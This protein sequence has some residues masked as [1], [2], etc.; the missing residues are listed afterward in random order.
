MPDSR[1]E[2]GCSCPACGADGTVGI[3]AV[4]NAPTNSCLLVDTVDEAIAFPRGRVDLRLCTGCGFVFNAA[5][6]PAKTVY[7]GRYEE[8]QGY[9]ATFTAFNR[10]IAES[11]IEKHG[12]HD[13]DVLEIGCGKGEF[14][15]MLCALG[16][17]RGVGYDPSHVPERRDTALDDRLRFVREFFTK[18]TQAPGSDFICCKMTL[19]HIPDVLTFVRAVRA[20]IEDGRE[21]I[22]FFQI[23]DLG[24]IFD[25]AAFWDVYYEHCSYFTA[26]SLERLFRRAGLK[27]TEVWTGYDGQY[28]MIEAV[29][30]VD[31]DKSA[32]S[33]D[34]EDV[35]RIVERAR[36]FSSDVAEKRQ[37]WSD[38][39]RRWHADGKRVAIWGSGSKA[40]AMLTTL[41]LAG[42]E[43]STV[44]DINP[45]RHGYFMPG[46]G[47][48]IVG[49]ETLKTDPPDV[50]V[51]M[52]PIYRTEIATE[53]K[54]LGLSPELHVVQ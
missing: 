10:G 17:N 31:D 51:I 46:S 1:A 53:L 35:A 16:P 42:D 6:D 9:S 26:G 29:P 54:R 48:R 50:V 40:V 13:K 33:S 39:L 44:V 38:R 18:D 19:E 43:V 3:Y 27:P 30:A 25:E 15:G 45:H 12:L 24:R 21:T 23:P 52:N 20:G 34:K 14:I 47:Q 4:D 7:S 28:L 11:L 49:P 8:T 37:L 2:M 5:F 41:D 22:V 32:V 36:Q